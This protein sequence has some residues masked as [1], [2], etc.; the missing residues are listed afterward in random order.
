MWD[1][2]AEQVETVHV[3]LEKNDISVAEVALL[4]VPRPAR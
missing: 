3:G 2:N 1:E 4:W